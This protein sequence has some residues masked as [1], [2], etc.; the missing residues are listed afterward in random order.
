MKLKVYNYSKLKTVEVI[1]FYYNSLFVLLI[2]LIIRCLNK[3]DI[4][5]LDARY[6]KRFNYSW[7]LKYIITIQFYTH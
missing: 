6:K 7:D 3:G 1:L 4:N 2:S 5:I